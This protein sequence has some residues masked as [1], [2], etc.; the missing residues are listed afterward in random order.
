MAVETT[1]AL[2]AKAHALIGQ[3]APQKRA[4]PYRYLFSDSRNRV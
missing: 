1:E 2:D 3:L 4:C